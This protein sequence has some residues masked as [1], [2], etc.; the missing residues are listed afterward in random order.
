MIGIALRKEAVLGS[1]LQGSVLRLL[2]FVLYI[3]DLPDTLVCP[4]IMFTDD[5]KSCRETTEVANMN[6]LQ[7][8][9]HQLEGWSNTWLLQF[10]PGK[11]V[12]MYVGIWWNIIQVHPYV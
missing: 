6:M 11:C 12:I 5:T 1:V 2:L 9:L 8:Y 7:N 10:H 3:N 4:S